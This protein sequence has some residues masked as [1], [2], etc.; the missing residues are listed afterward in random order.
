LLAI[1]EEAFRM[2]TLV[3][4]LFALLLVILGIA[5]LCNPSQPAQTTSQLQPDPGANSQTVDRTAPRP[6]M[7][8]A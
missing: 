5:L 2:K 3:Q 1:A 4:Y 6:L 8:L 7:R